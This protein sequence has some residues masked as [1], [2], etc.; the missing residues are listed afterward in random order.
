MILERESR[1]AA[2]SVSEVFAFFSDPKNLARI[3]PRSLGFKILSAPENGLRQGDRIEYVIRVLG[4]PLR[5]TTLIT[6]WTEGSSFADLQERGPYKKW[7]HTHTFRQAG[8]DVVMN[9]RV[10]YEL[11]FGLAGKLLAGPLVRLQLRAIF[12]YR[13]RVIGTI[14]AR[15]N[16]PERV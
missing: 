5:W 12:N 2:I 7:L 4:I 15:E 3:T 14:F 1:I 9:D 13:E 11:P 10:D 8:H 6:S 16:R